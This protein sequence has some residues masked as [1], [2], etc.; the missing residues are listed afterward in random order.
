MHQ[1][2]TEIRK[3]ICH[4]SKEL[5]L[6]RHS[7]ELVMVR[8]YLEARQELVLADLIISPL[9]QV[10]NLQGQICILDEMLEVLR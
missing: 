2:R 9:D 7:Q 6:L 8:K 4:L 3:E 10:L 5:K 1:P